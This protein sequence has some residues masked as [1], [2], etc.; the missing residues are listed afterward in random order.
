MDATLLVQDALEVVLVHVLVGVVVAPVAVVLVVLITVVEDALG[1]AQEAA[2]APVLV[3][4]QEIVTAIAMGAVQNFVWKTVELGA[5]PFVV[6]IVN[7]NVMVVLGLVQLNAM[8]NLRAMVDVLE[9]A[10]DGFG[11]NER[12]KYI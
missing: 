9:V 8:M 3:V 12:R 4:A 6:M 2:K 1:A 7:T 10:K 5:H 11:N